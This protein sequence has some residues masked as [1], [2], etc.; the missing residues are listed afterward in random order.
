MSELAAIQWAWQ[1]LEGR[2]N[3]ATKR[4]TKAAAVTL[5]PKGL[6]KMPNMWHFGNSRHRQANGALERVCYSKIGRPGEGIIIVTNSDMGSCSSLDWQK[7][8]DIALLGAAMPESGGS[9]MPVA[10]LQIAG[11]VNLEF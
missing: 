3:L 5:H 4:F 6:C 2:P 1:Y 11:R 8:V 9:S 7:K 10:V